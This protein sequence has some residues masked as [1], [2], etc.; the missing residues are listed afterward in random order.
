MAS[1]VT[2]HSDAGLP[3]LAGMRASFFFGL[4][5]PRESILNTR[6][7]DMRAGS[8]NKGRWATPPSFLSS[9]C[10]SFCSFSIGA[11]ST[12]RTNTVLAH[13]TRET[14][15]IQASSRE[16]KEREPGGQNIHFRPSVHFFLLLFWTRP[17]RTRTRRQSDTTAV[18]VLFSLP[19]W[20]RPRVRG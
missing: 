4:F 3:L 15:W 5:A 18:V 7:M 20:L 16:R 13:L 6:Q 12:Q 2:P 17:I 11:E 9:F 8:A 14:G 19:V 10:P 1:K